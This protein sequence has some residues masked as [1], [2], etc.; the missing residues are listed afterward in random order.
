MRHFQLATDCFLVEGENDAALYDVHGG[1][2]FLLDQAAHRLLR[3]CQ[4]GIPVPD[5][6]SE[7]EVSLL[8]AL[9]TAGLGFFDAG[10]GG[11]DKLLLHQPIEWKGMCMTP[12][13][14]TSVDW[15]LTN[16]CDLECAFCGDGDNTLSWQ[17]CQSCLRRNRNSAE[18]WMP[19]NIEEFVAEIANLG[20]R[21]LHI[22]GGNPVLAWDALQ[23]ISRAIEGTQ[24]TLVITTAGTHCPPEDLIALGNDRRFCIN[25]VMFGVDEMTSQK[26]CGRSGVFKEQLTLI[27]ALVESRIFFSI[28]FLLT[29]ST[30]RHRNAMRSFAQQHWNVDPAFSETCTRE[31]VNSGFH[32]SHLSDGAKPLAPWESAEMFFFRVRNNTCAA[33][34]FEIG[35]DGMLRSCS[36]LSDVHGDVGR[37]GLRAALSGT[38]L[39]E[40]WKRG[41]ASVEPCGHCALRCACTD[42]ST[43]EFDGERNSKTKEAYCPHDPSQGAIRA[44]QRAWKPPEFVRTLRLREDGAQSAEDPVP[45]DR[46][47]AVDL[48]RY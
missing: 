43:F 5:G 44:Y 32:L 14:F 11:N 19:D 39:Y 42:C 25:L 12:P 22:R 33:G 41:K 37:F 28:T 23:R 10:H 16:A 31:D 47:T 4:G 34:T 48:A 20:V 27:D 35:A 36:G 1:R 15:Q 8:G 17:S 24:L 9:Q 2:L 46:G 45:D 18:A 38:G 26:V 13:D 29:P 40:T 6:A 21:I 30:Q 3:R 7:N